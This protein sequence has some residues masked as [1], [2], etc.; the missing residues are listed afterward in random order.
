MGFIF[1]RWETRN[2]DLARHATLAL[3]KLK[4]IL[5]GEGYA[6]F[7]DPD[8]SVI[9]VGE[10]GALL[11]IVFS[12]RSG[13]RIEAFDRDAAAEILGS[14]GACLPK[15]YWGAYVAILPAE[16]RLD[17]VRDPSGA[18]QTWRL[19]AS[20][21][22]ILTSDLALAERA[23][24]LGFVRDKGGVAQMLAYPQIRGRRTG[25]VGVEELPAGARLT[26][27]HGGVSETQLWTPWTFADKALRIDSIGVARDQLRRT[28]ERVVSLWGRAYPRSLLELSGGLDSSLIAL[29]LPKTPSMS[30]INIVT[31][32]ADGDERDYARLTAEAASLRLV[33]ATVAARSDLEVR[34]PGRLPRPGAHVYLQAIEQQIIDTAQVAQ[35]SAFFSGLGGDN[36]LCG[37][38]TA[39]PG[40]DAL[41]VYGPGS[42]S[43]TTIGDLARVHGCTMWRAAQ[44][45]IAKALRP[46]VQ[47]WDRQ[48]LLLNRDVD[49]APPEHPWFD[50]PSSVL[51]GKRD[52]VRAI[53]VAHAFLDRYAHAQAGA[54]IAPMMAQPMVE[55]CL[56]IP[57]WMWVEGG[58]NRAVARQAFAHLLPARVRL[59]AT[60]G[61]LGGFA[62]SVYRQVRPQLR[63]FLGD[64]RLAQDGL[65][66][67]ERLFEVLGAEQLPSATLMKVFLLV[68][69][70]VWA[71]GWDP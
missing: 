36:V 52:H 19:N 50:A 68:D 22:D 42:R 15:A 16:G 66:D 38:S 4:L 7:V 23:S 10:R 11:G 3:S 44:L 45:S 35:A 58:Q 17:V 24:G 29:C 18:L 37:I 30:A 25:L 27:R 2:A 62:A 47:G 40:A 41:R 9:E 59:R 67:R 54:I 61:G 55:L 8:A 70:E 60:K 14:Q 6:L 71:R 26:W 31:V 65:L 1:L 39:G 51:P 33:E 48:P 46:P 43:W 5:Q 49:V 28:L 57:T 34:R 69:T 53:L 12:Q 20:G 64:G 63:A 56:R 32:E 13:E 21:L